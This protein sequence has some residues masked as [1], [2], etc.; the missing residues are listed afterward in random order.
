MNIDG[1]D[2]TVIGS[3]QYGEEANDIW[4]LTRVSS[5]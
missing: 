1:A 4:S 3:A 5:S 2:S